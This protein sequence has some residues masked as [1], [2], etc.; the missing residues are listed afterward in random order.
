M[1]LLNFQETFFWFTIYCL[2][3]PCVFQFPCDLRFPS[4]LQDTD[5]YFKFPDLLLTVDSCIFHVAVETVENKRL[6]QFATLYSCK[7]FVLME[8]SMTCATANF[9][10]LVTIAWDRQ[11]RILQPSTATFENVLAFTH[12]YLDLSLHIFYAIYLERYNKI[13]RNLLERG[14]RNLKNCRKYAT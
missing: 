4:K 2:D 9:S 6:Q 1:H 5:K 12:S 3:I 7:A 11:K 10:S 13:T 8:L 14:K